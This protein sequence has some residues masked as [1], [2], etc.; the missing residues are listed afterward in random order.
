VLPVVFFILTASLSA[1]DLPARRLSA[2]PPSNFDSANLPNMPNLEAVPP[3]AVVVPYF[4]LTGPVSSTG[5]FSE[6]AR[7]LYE[8]MSQELDWQS[9]IFDFYTVVKSRSALPDSPARESLPSA[10]RA[11]RYVITGAISYDDY[12]STNS[13]WK[14]YTLTAWTP[15]NGS[16]DRSVQVSLAYIEP[17]E[18]LD[19]IPFLVWQLTSVFPV[20]TTPLPKWG[21]STPEDQVWKHKWLYAG[22]ALGGSAGFYDR[23]SNSRNIGTGLEAALRLEFQFLTLSQTPNYFSLSLISGA[24]FNMESVSYRDYIPGTGGLPDLLYTRSLIAASL[25]YS[26]GFFDK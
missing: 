18:V 4:V 22:L 17:R 10:N 19:Y 3:E 16:A 21:A 14:L 1:Q 13:Q 6:E 11:A 23:D 5:E 2:T 24:A 12:E 9:S 25:G 8:A 20:D 15:V 26:F 7:I